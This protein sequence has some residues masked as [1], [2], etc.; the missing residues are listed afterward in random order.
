MRASLLV[1][2]CTPLAACASTSSGAPGSQATAPVAAPRADSIVHRL[3]V[4]GEHVRVLFAAT[5]AQPVRSLVGNLYSLAGDTLV[6][7]RGIQADTVRLGP[8]LRLQVAIRSRSHAR[9]GG[10]IGA[11]IG[12]VVGALAGAAAYEPCS[13]LGCLMAP[14]QGE[15]IAG[16]AF[17]GAGA[18]ALLGLLVGSAVMT[19]EWATV[20]LER[21]RAAVKLEAVRM[22]TAF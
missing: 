9:T 5:A 20:D 10:A 12:L 17:I 8:D 11:S 3:P 6:L 13:G 21:A 15:A 22:T 7:S 18:G 19:D 14:S 1:L 16:G 4:R 2:L